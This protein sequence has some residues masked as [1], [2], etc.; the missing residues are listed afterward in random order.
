M[1]KEVLVSSIVFFMLFSVAFAS[2]TSLGFNPGTFYEAQT[3]EFN[4]SVNNFAHNKMINEINL[5]L[6]GFTI[7][8]VTDFLGWSNSFTNSTVRWFGGTVENNVFL[9][10][11][12]FEAAAPLVTDNQSSNVDVDVKYSDGTNQ[13]FQIP[14]MLLNDYTGPVLS[15]S[16]PSDGGFLRANEASQQIS[17]TVVDEETG[18]K[19]VK[20][21]WEECVNGTETEIALSCNNI[22]CTGTADFSTYDEGE[23][24]CFDFEAKNNANELTTLSGTAGFDGTAPAVELISPADGASVG[25]FGTFTFKATDNLAT[26]LDCDFV[27]NG[28]VYDSVQ[29]QNNVV[30]NIIINF[31]AAPEGNNAWKVSCSDQVGLIANSETRDFNLDKTAPSITLNSPVNGSIIADSGTIDITVTDNYV[32]ADVQ[33]SRDLNDLTTWPAGQNDVIITATDSAGNIATETFTFFIDRTPPIVSNLAPAD[34]ANIDVHVTFTFDVNDDYDPTI[35]CKLLLNGQEDLTATF[36]SGT[37]GS[38]AKSLALGAF[39]WSIQCADDA[40]NSMTTLQ[41]SLTTI[42]LS[43]PDIALQDIVTV[44]RGDSF[45]IDATITDVSGVDNVYAELGALAVALNNDGDKYY[46]DVATNAA[47]TLGNYSYTVYANDTLGYTNNVADVFLLV[48]NYVFTL[49]LSP[50]T[51]SPEAS[52]TLTGSVIDDENANIPETTLELTLPS[53]AVDVTIDANGDFSYT[54][55][56]PADPGVY[57]ITVEIDGDN[58][59]TYTDSVQLTVQGM[60]GSS[61]RGSSGRGFKQHIEEKPKEVYTEN[62]DNENTFE[63]ESDDGNSDDSALVVVEEAPIETE[64]HGIG[65]SMGFFSAPIFKW[66]GALILAMIVISLAVMGFSRMKKEGPKQDEWSQYLQRRREE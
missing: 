52:V 18:V 9:A 19:E 10:L 62:S 17:I 38:F 7:T 41:R 53:G 16:V 24:V 59:H 5:A 30:S 21:S 27:L 56:A 45:T 39:N 26:T 22:L 63:E 33:T 46:Q 23:E 35:D 29:V 50:S 58:R 1:R 55:T 64:V 66:L 60:G 42:D 34:N 4:L 44:A 37:Q 6:S 2:A 40:G 25:L 61:G 28:A 57:D 11:F 49:S 32:L 31:T 15:N 14:V 48:K 36:D 12:Q 13:M 8:D 43:G 65:Q 47:S 51:A 54:F 3:H 20:F